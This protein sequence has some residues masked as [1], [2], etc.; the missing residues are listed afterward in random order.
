MLRST[1]SELS[2]VNAPGATPVE[3]TTDDRG[4]YRVYGLSPG[5]YYVGATPP[6][7]AMVGRETTDA[8]VAWALA[9][10]KISGTQPGPQPPA[11]GP[12]PGATIA[13]VPSFYPSGNTVGAARPIRLAEAEELAGVDIRFRSEPAF[14]LSGT[15]VGAGG[16]GSS[17]ARLTLIPD[18]LSVPTASTAVPR[19]RDSPTATVV[20]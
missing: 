13:Q 2:L 15:V 4:E 3:A 1:G 9:Q 18:G 7:A 10:A 17:G 11:Q 19:R 8:D 16:Q 14:T 12:A 5:E 6:P 20:W